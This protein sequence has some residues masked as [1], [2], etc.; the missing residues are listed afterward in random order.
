[1]RFVLA[2]LLAL[3]GCLSAPLSTD[4]GHGPLND[5]GAWPS[6]DMGSFSLPDAAAAAPD[7]GAPLDLSRTPTDSGESPPGDMGLVGPLPD[8]AAGDLALAGGFCD[9]TP[10]ALA[11]CVV[12][13]FLPIAACFQTWGDCSEYKSAAGGATCWQSGARL[14]ATFDQLTMS[15][16]GVWTGPSGDC[17]TGIVAA[18]ANGAAALFTLTRGGATLI[19]DAGTGMVTCPDGSTTTIGPDDGSCAALKAIL[20]PSTNNC[21]TGMCP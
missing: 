7:L 21:A 1:M 14:V 18:D 8:A 12:A 3:S 13:F 4:G 10:V 5:G 6:L 9:G 11:P 20:D 2:G 17:M 15:T 16:S 19:Y